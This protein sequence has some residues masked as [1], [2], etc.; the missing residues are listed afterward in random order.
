MFLPFIFLSFKQFNNFSYPDEN[1]GQIFNM[2]FC[3][4]IFIAFLMGAVALVVYCSKQYYKLEYE[5][6]IK[7][8]PSIYYKKIPINCLPTEYHRIVYPL[9]RYFKIFLFCLLVALLGIHTIIVFVLMIVIN[10]G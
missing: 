6:F 8:F 9:L 2:L 10:A 1:N 4:L 3:L 7:S 5:I